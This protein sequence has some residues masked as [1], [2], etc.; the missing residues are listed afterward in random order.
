MRGPRSATPRARPPAGIAIRGLTFD[1]VAVALLAGV[2]CAGAGGGGPTG[3]VTDSAGIRIVKYDLQRGAIPVHRLVGEIEQE[4]G[5][6]E[7]PPEYTF[8]TVTDL[9]MAADGRYVVSDRLAQQIRVYD[10]DGEHVASL[11]HPGDGP[12]EFSTAPTI[13]GVACDT[14]FAFDPRAARVS[15]FTLGDVLVGTAS[16]QWEEYGRPTELI[17]M[18][19]GGYL[20]R[21]A[22]IDVG[23][24]LEAHDVRL[25]VDSIVVQRLGSDG[26]PLDTLAVLP[27]RARVR[28]RQVT[29][30]GA[31][32]MIQAD[33]PYLPRAFVSSD[34]Q[35]VLVARNDAFELHILDEAGSTSTLL[36]VNGVAHPATAT[37]I[38]AEQEAR[39]RAELGDQ[40]LD[41]LMRRLNFEFL[42]ERL[43]AFA[44]ILI[45]DTGD[46]WVA[47]QE[48]DGTDGLDWLVFAPELELRGVV[49]TPPNVQLF[50]AS[51][52]WIVGVYRDELDVPFVRRYPLEPSGRE[53]RP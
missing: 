41:P 47:L 52:D 16:M 39:V 5:L 51:E 20:A 17:R 21:S 50:H 45:A 49:R 2:G 23:S 34:G 18:D 8:S 28:A 6:V 30:A 26:E 12:G 22:L 11:G 31:Q 4:I 7:G 43:P 27:D 10:A 53:E 15:V 19:G 25:E 24:P 13:A 40:E 3:V 32:R 37:D 36:R 14:V 35:R 44:A 29:A 48:L 1:V 9:A 33:P 38:R 46:V 42:P